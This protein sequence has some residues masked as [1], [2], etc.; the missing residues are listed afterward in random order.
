MLTIG[1][2]QKT[3]TSTAPTDTTAFAVA[4]PKSNANREAAN[5]THFKSVPVR[6][7]EL[8]GVWY[9]VSR[10]TGVVIQFIGRQSREPSTRGV[11]S[12]KWIVHVDGGSISSA[13]EFVDNLQSGAVDLRVGMVNNETK[14]IFTA[15]LGHIQR[16]NG[17]RLYLSINKNNASD[18]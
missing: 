3:S 9:G 15:S 17:G 7:A 10:E 11:L 16:G 8:T 13:V 2:G 4:D 12:S 18:L 5:P 1:C 6:S 14:E